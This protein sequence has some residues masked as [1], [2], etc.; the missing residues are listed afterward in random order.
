[1]NEKFYN[2]FS[3]EFRY[4]RKRCTWKN[5]ALSCSRVV[6]ELIA[7]FSPYTIESIQSKS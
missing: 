4:K 6:L 7:L 2:L 5:L 3:L 1:M